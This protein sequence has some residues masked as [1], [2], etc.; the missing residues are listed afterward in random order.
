[1]RVVILINSDE[2]GGVEHIAGV[3]TED[4][5]KQGAIAQT[6]FLFGAT[7]AP[8]LM[9][10]IGVARA[11]AQLIRD[12]PDIVVSY[13]PSSSVIA[14]YVGRLAGCGVRLAHQSNTPMNAPLLLRLLDKNAGRFGFYSANIANS[15]TTKGEFASYP[16]AY[17]NCMVRI[18]HG[19]PKPTTV[20]SRSEILATYAIPDDRPILFCAARLDPKKRIDI[21]L[22]ALRDIPQARLV[23]AGAGPDLDRL[24]EIA[25]HYRLEG[26]VHFI[27]RV[28][29]Q[30]VL[31]L[32]AACSLFVFPTLVES[33]GLAPVEAATSGVPVIVSDIGV[34]HEVLSVDG[35]S[36]A[37]FVTGQ[38]PHS[39]ALAIRAALDDP[40]LRK[41]ARDFAFRLQDKYSETRMLMAY[42]ELFARLL[43]PVAKA[44]MIAAGS[45][46]RGMPALSPPLA[47]AQA[48]TH[49]PNAII[50]WTH[51]GR[52]ASGIE[53]VTA[54]LFSQSSL[55][56]LRVALRTSSGGRTAM[57]LKQ[58]L[59]LPL[60]AY[61]SPKS[62]WIFPGYPPSP[63][64][65][66][67][68]ERT[69]LYVHD[70][71]LLS[72]AE[73]L[74]QAARYYMAPNFRRAVTRLKYFLVN[75]ETTRDQLSP[76]VAKDAEIQ[77][78]RPRVA[79]VF[80]L[81]HRAR[82]DRYGPGQPLIV[83][84]IGTIEPRKNFLAGA[85]IC[86]ALS[87]RLGIPVEY[88]VV[89]RVGWGEDAKLLEQMPHVRLH[90][91]LPD[92]DARRVI[93]NFDL[94]L[95]TSHDE[96]LGLPLIEAQYAGLQIVAP[97][98]AVFREVLADS[99]KY[100]DATDPKIAAN[101]IASLVGESGWRNRAAV[102]AQANIAR[103]QALADGD[104][105]NFARLLARMLE[106]L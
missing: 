29:R 39:W 13:Q 34:L 12:R 93:E 78:Y 64:F 1:M 79:N 94:F 38:D 28:P 74:N 68:R 8:A 55:A 33:F 56:P 87:A 72:R 71:F 15:L 59:T 42:R 32:N 50:D 51:M 100:I 17:R 91:F 22:G 46:D 106:K 61:R 99:G 85:R 21:L 66:Y 76:Y 75:S 30:S 69:I 16:E 7:R 73:D 83:G 24:A 96:G 86:E 98:Q 92:D 81:R 65:R 52:R 41:S 26:R 53:R 20:A 3:L 35:D 101:Q 62:V 77:V 23:V 10:L 43:S 103:W 54:E 40:A 57:I 14:G 88:H 82:P 19:L 37:I 95:S 6:R 90:G 67:F 5:A 80:G 45:A 105:K 25:K 47:S 63:A 97:E 104:Q 11:G 44:D 9:K 4:L 60:Q 58:M 27:G 89:G 84:A 36:P 2:G 31:D 18:D 102:T 49:A 70:I 48:D